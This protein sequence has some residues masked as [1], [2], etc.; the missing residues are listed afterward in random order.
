MKT[1]KPSISVV[2][3]TYNAVDWLEK[4]LW[5]YEVQTT[6]DFEIVIADDGSGPETKNLLDK[7]AIDFPVPIIHVWQVIV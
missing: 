2:L 1:S 7:M 3:S 6:T 4:T 5:G